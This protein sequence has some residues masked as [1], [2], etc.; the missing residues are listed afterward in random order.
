MPKSKK[1]KQ[2]Q[3]QNT[4]EEK[5]DVKTSMPF[6]NFLHYVLLIMHILISFN[7]IYNTLEQPQF[8]FLSL[9]LTYVVTSLLVFSVVGVILYIIGK[10]IFCKE[11]DLNATEFLV[12]SGYYFIILIITVVITSSGSFEWS[13]ELVELRQQ[14]EL[15]KGGC[16][17]V[18]A[19][20]STKPYKL[21]RAVIYGDCPYVQNGTIRIEKE[22]CKTVESTSKC[23]VV[24][25]DLGSE[26]LN[27]IEFNPGTNK[28]GYFMLVELVYAC[29]A[30]YEW[31]KARKLKY[32]RD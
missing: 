13:K 30:L 15:E 20:Y 4:Q 5:H 27:G 14:Q 1:S 9:N 12:L 3:K 29:C 8:A 11:K 17:Y 21:Y 32:Y 23:D 7:Y 2:K 28:F 6:F 26:Y 10:K 19:Y 31:N 25:E 18:E 16:Y 24:R 22:L